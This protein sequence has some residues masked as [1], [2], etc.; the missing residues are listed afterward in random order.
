MTTKK[1]VTTADVERCLLARIERGQSTTARSAADA[2]GCSETTARKLLVALCASRRVVSAWSPVWHD[3]KLRRAKVFSLV[4]PD[5]AEAHEA[6][7]AE[8]KRNRA[9]DERVT[10]ALAGALSEAIGQEGWSV[11][12][13]HS[14]QI[15]LT[16][17]T[18]ATR[19]LIAKLTGEEVAS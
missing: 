8:R 7:I 13:P 4:G 3:G 2:L 11:S 10:V 19:L 6:F 18:E 1:K 12:Q 17:Y 9:D 16:L 14:G 5:A 15:K